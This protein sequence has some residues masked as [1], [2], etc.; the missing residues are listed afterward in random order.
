MSYVSI[1]IH[2]VWSTKNREPFFQTQD[3]RQ[4]VFDHIRRHSE[5]QAISI[6]SINGWTDHVHV[7]LSMRSTQTIAGIVKQLKG[8]SSRWLKEQQ[9]VPAYFAWQADYFAISVSQSV[10]LRTRAY[11]QCQ[12]Q[13]HRNQ[14]SSDEYAAMLRR[15]GFTE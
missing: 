2:V 13:H 7:L 3:L 5:Q 11:I 4:I 6:D 10:L 14:T 12:E 1:W 9:L 15:W 8:E